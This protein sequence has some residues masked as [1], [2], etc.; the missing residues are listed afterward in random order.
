MGDGSERLAA[1]ETN[2]GHLSDDVKSQTDAVT[3]LTDFIT[4]PENGIGVR[5]KGQEGKLKGLQAD[6]A[7]IKA[8]DRRRTGWLGAGIIGVVIN[9]VFDVFRRGG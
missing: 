8:T 2:L 5:L 7:D 9:S 3:K 4:D 1:I 6:V